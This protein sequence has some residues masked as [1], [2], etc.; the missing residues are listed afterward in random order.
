MSTQSLSA[1]PID[2]YDADGSAR[3]TSGMVN[4][5]LDFGDDDGWSGYVGVGVGLASVKYNIDRSTPI[6]DIRCFAT[7]TAGLPG[8]AL[9]AFARRSAR[10]SILA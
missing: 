9:P 10:T 2:A 1:V 8:R 3:A 6:V 7:A 5:L 4:V